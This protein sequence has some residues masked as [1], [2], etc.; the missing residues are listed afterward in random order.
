MGA[1]VPSVVLLPASRSWTSAA[2][3]HGHLEHP[4]R[5]LRL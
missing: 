4:T 1:A 5:H 3:S 2:L